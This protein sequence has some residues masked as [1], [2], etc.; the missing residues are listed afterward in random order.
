MV[1]AG[2]QQHDRSSQPFAALITYSVKQ[3][4]FAHL[5][6]SSFSLCA[7]TLRD[8]CKYEFKTD[9]EGAEPYQPAYPQLGGPRCRSGPKL[10]PIT[11]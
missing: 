5:P 10:S 4:L 7:K 3:S 9:A 1:F 2:L 8:S 6:L 11:T